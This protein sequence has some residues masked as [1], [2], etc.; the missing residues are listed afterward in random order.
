VRDGAGV[1]VWR[2]GRFPGDEGGRVTRYCEGKKVDNEQQAAMLAL[3]IT[4]LKTAK[5]AREVGLFDHEPIKHL[6][7]ALESDA[8]E[9]LDA[10]AQVGVH[11]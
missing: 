10:V 8:I 6:L 3:I 11:P 9:A 5:L 7:R 2:A 1:R 4:A